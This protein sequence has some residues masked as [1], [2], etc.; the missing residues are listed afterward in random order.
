[1]YIEETY[2]LFNVYLI[3]LFTYLPSG[4]NVDGYMLN[5]HLSTMG[6]AYTAYVINTYIDWIIRN[7]GNAFRDTALIGTGYRADYTK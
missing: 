7:N 4:Y 1:M 3:D 5:G 2:S 6:Y